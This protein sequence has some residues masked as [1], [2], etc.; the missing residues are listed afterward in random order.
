MNNPCQ[1][2]T[3]QKNFTIIFNPVA[4]NLRGSLLKKSV[5]ALEAEDCKVTVVGTTGPGNATDLAKEAVKS[6]SDVIVAA[7]GDGTINEVVA[8]MIDSHVPLD[9]IPLGTANVLAQELRLPSRSRA[10]AKVLLEDNHQKVHLPRLNDEPFLLMVGAGFDGQ[11]VG[12]ISPCL[13][14]KVGEGAFVLEGLKALL[15]PTHVPVN[16]VADGS[17]HSAEWVVV[18][19][20]KHYGGPYRITERAEAS[21]PS[22]VAV[23]FHKAQ[24]WDLFKCLVRLGIGRLSRNPNVTQIETSQ[25]S[26]RSTSGATVPVQTDGDKD[27]VL[28]LKIKATNDCVKVLIPEIS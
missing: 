3:H 12:N 23:L 4:G 19:N 25:I 18:T 5:M 16:I 15:H 26:L 1:R 7:G 27:G 17:E 14:R 13:K 9:I 20:I 24:G 21:Q 8:G 6:V 10:I 2:T 22:L 11:V 28:P